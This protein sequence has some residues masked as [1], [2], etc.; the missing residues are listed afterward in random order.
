MARLRSSAA[1]LLIALLATP[2]ASA[3]VADIT[4]YRCTG[5]DGA[6]T[7]SDDPCPK[8][9]QQETRTMQRPEAPPPRPVAPAAAEADPPVPAAPARREVVV[10]RAP[11]PTYECTTPDGEVYTS[12][13]P[14]GNPRWVPLWT[15]GYPVYHGPHRP[16]A[17]PRPVRPAASGRGDGLVFDNVG[18]PTPRPPT[19]DGIRP[20]PPAGTT[21]AY[22]AGTWIRDQCHAIPAA[23]VCERLRDRSRELWRGYN[24]ALQ[25]EREAIVTERRAIQTRLDAECPA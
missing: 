2:A 1:C 25:S 24:S 3:A 21:A 16:R 22:G 17:A 5:Q 6:V 7:L 20:A 10:V 23:E 11:P 19:G 9:Q 4:I 12:D 15:L 14:A 13:S 8:G 18:R